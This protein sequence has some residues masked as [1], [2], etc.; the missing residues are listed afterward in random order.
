M[1][2]RNKSDT[3]EEIIAFIKHTELQVENKVKQLKSNHGIDFRNFTMESFYEENGIA[4]N[5]SAVR[6]LKQNDIAE[7]KTK[8]L[9]RQI[10][11]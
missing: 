8:Q 6:T 1:F 4:K 5:F 7:R 9:L 2:L 3:N 10:E 11:Q